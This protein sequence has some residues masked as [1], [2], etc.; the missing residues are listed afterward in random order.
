MDRPIIFSA[1]MIRAL[2]DGRKTQTR[3]IVKKPAAMDALAV[4]GPSFLLKPGCADLLPYATGDRLWV[5]EAWRTE[6]R[7]DEMR[8]ADLLPPTVAADM[9]Q[10]VP[11]VSYEA[12]YAEE[13]NDGC[14]GRLRPSIHMPRWASRLTLVDVDVRVERLQQISEDDARAEG[15]GQNAGDG[16]WTWAPKGVS[17]SGW[18]SARG[19]F[20]ALWTSIN[21]PDAWATNPWVCAISFR[22]IKANIDTAGAS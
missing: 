6:A 1:L 19:A 11:L 4:F 3:R 7:Y 10:R 14:R 13:P 5:R 22:T 20:D 17:V 21:G 8:P 2:L 18:H 9:G 15:I 16:L 12:D